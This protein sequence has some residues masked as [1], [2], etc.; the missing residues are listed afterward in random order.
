MVLKCS[1]RESSKYVLLVTGIGFYSIIVASHTCTANLGMS[2]GRS[3]GNIAQTAETSVGLKFST[4]F[5]LTVYL[6][7]I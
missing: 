4:F 5:F 6:L 3:I 7:K 2:A 1:L